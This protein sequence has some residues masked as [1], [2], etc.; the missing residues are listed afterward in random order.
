MSYNYG[1]YKIVN[2]NVCIRM[3]RSRSVS[4]DAGGYESD[5]I[6]PGPLTGVP[7]R[8]RLL[9]PICQRRTLVPGSRILHIDTMDGKEGRICLETEGDHASKKDLVAS[10]RCYVHNFEKE[11]NISTALIGNETIDVVIYSGIQ[12][13]HQTSDILRGLCR[14]LRPGGLLLL[15]IFLQEKMLETNTENTTCSDDGEY[16]R[17]ILTYLRGQLSS[18]GFSLIVDETSASMESSE[19][20]DVINIEYYGSNE[21][22]YAYIAAERDAYTMEDS[23]LLEIDTSGR[24]VYADWSDNNISQ[25]KGKMV[26]S[27]RIALYKDMVKDARD[28]GI[29]ASAIPSLPL[30]PTKDDVSRARSHLA[31][32][33]SSFVC[34]GL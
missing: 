28:L 15:V 3:P 34:S 10:T 4:M 2:I 26:F 9:P 22:P 17:K 29:P 18:S 16:A 14:I 33:M 12:Y 13:V 11:P 27:T 6:R 21:W 32:I 19:G 31:A 1:A 25:G 7:F 30:N 24:L 20:D 8:R 23:S 5:D